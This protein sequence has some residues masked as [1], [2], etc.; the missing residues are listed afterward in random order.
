ML[1]QGVAV[2]VGAALGVLRVR[3]LWNLKA[4]A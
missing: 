1:M 4:A 2:G 3:V